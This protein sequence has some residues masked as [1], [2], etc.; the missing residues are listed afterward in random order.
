MTIVAGALEVGPAR[1]EARMREQLAM[2]PVP[3]SPEAAARK[4]AEDEAL[5]LDPTAAPLMRTWCRKCRIYGCPTHPDVILPRCAVCGLAGACET[6]PAH[7]ELFC[8][9]TAYRSAR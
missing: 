5:S 6:A 2:P 3:P 1:L 9:H 7:L 4:A 8:K